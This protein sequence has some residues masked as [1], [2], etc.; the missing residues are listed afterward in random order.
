MM[1]SASLRLFL[2]R[3]TDLTRSSAEDLTETEIYKLTLN[4]DKHV[5]CSGSLTK[6]SHDKISGYA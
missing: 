6:F 3:L 4:S 5:M 1:I 2:L